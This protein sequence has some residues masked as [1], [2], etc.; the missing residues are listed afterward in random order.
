MTNFEIVLYTVGAKGRCKIILNVS[1]WLVVC[2]LMRTRVIHIDFLF[3]SFMHVCGASA[4]CAT[5]S[6]YHSGTDCQKN[7]LCSSCAFTCHAGHTVVPFLTQHKPS[8]ACCYCKKTKC[9]Q[10]KKKIAVVTKE[11]GETKT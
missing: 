7:W 10:L 8:F 11:G 5:H 3:V 9:C 4:S 6:V 2:G 1:R